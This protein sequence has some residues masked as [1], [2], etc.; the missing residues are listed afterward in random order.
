M[1]CE[2]SKDANGYDVCKWDAVEEVCMTTYCYDTYGVAPAS[3]CA[4]AEDPEGDGY[5]DEGGEDGIPAC[6]NG[7]ICYDANNGVLHEGYAWCCAACNGQ[8]PDSDLT[9][10]ISGATCPVASIDCAG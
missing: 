10:Q 4:A 7:D 8:D 1:G 9:D 2:A 6:L 5:G 3:T